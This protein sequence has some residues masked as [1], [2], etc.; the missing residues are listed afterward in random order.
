MIDAYN[1][2]IG[3]PTNRQVNFRHYSFM[4]NSIKYTTNVI[5]TE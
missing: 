1:M 2:V 3:I 5:Y 4:N